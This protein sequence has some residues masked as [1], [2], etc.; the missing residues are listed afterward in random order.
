MHCLYSNSL[1]GNCLYAAKVWGA[2]CRVHEELAAAQ[3]GLDPGEGIPG[4]YN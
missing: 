2:E 4:T 3:H 1:N